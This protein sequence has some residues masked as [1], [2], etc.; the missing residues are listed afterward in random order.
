MKVEELSMYGK[1]LTM[2]KKGLKKQQKVVF[3]FLR[4][5]FGLFGLIFIMMG[6][7]KHT[8][9]IKKEYPAAI[10]RAENIGKDMD[11]QLCM[12]GGLFFSIADKKGKKY[13]TEF[14]TKMF[15]N[16][17][18]VS[19]PAIY[20]LDEL[21]NCEGD[22]F[23]NFK[24]FN[25]AMFT[26]IDRIGT[27]KNSGFHETDDLLEFKVTSCMNMELFE[28]IGC[29]EIGTL[30]CDHDLAGFPLIEDVVN[31]EFRRPCTLAKGGD[32][33]HFYFHRKGT[34]PDTAHLNK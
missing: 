24:R 2:P 29:P 21:L 25:R 14:M 12:L 8:R 6:V 22:A 20:Q 32:C 9:R 31:C 1:A 17:A 18:S 10:K 13:A 26:E 33:C 19:M 11:K 28:E 3:H 23:D 16:V 34:A 27:W 5:E 30:G 7:K 4:K 15:Q